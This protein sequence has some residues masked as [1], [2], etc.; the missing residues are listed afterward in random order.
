MSLD[1]AADQ[2]AGIMAATTKTRKARRALIDR[3]SSAKEGAWLSAGDLLK[4]L[5]G[6]DVLPAFRL[7]IRNWFAEAR[8]EGPR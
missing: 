8:R 4:Q 7:R 3:E 1:V 6:G 2:G 5:G